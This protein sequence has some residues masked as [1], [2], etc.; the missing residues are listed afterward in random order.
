VA[1]GYAVVRSSTLAWLIDRHRTAPEAP[2]PMEVAVDLRE[3]ARDIRA[4]RPAEE[5]MRLAGPVLSEEQHV[6]LLA[7]GLDL[8]AGKA[9]EFWRI[10]VKVVHRM[11]TN[12]GEAVLH[13]IGG[14]V[15]ERRNED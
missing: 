12:E 5:R 4:P 13:L 14:D 7:E 9:G 3:V 8:P 2:L 11:L 10:V 1:D 6:Q 15:D